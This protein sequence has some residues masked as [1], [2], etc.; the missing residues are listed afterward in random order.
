MKTSGN[1]VLITGGATGIGF[2]LAAALSNQ[3]NEVIICG[4]REEKLSE[5]KEKLPGISI[6]TCDISQ[7]AE[8][9]SLFDWVTS[10]FPGINVLVNNAGMQRAIDF[11]KGVEDLIKNEDEINVNLKA[12]IYLAAYFVPVFSR[13]QTES[14][15]INVSSGLA[16][17]PLA[18]FPIYCATKAA[19][20]SFTISL[21]HQLRVTPIRVFEV[22]PPT[23]Y[24]TELKGKPLQKS[25]WTVS[26]YE[27][28]DAV[29]KGLK[30]NDYEI[31][32]GAAKNW[33]NGS[34]NELEIAFNNMN[35]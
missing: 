3:G 19:I 20:H 14:A 35:R 12:Q 25:D 34:K 27:V 4:R 23:V 33:I 28:A 24:D 5:A 2:A 22:I 1:T 13:R 6:R 9:E 29:M 15:I 16:F 31:S 11:R 8:I 30:N 26:S 7:Q 10:N 32:L 21:R 17:V 18:K